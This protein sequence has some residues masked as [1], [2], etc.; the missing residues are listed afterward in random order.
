MTE[1][2]FSSEA[3]DREF[4]EVLDELVGETGLEKFRVEYE[5]LIDA[6]KKS[7]ENKT[8]LMKKTHE[9]NAEIA[10]N[11][12]KLATAVKLSQED[13]TTITSLKKVH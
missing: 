5:K 10:S 2:E 9:L 4:Q 3:L 13:E 6:L 7:D 8:R 12:L 1:E 11:A